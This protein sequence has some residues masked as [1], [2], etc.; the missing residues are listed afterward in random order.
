MRSRLQ[1]LRRRVTMRANDGERSDVPQPAS[2]LPRPPVIIVSLSV[3]A[4][5]VLT[6]W[7]LVQPQPLLIQGDADATRIDI[8]ARVDGRVAKRL[9]HRGQDG[10][11]GA[12]LVT[13]D[14]P[15]LLTKLTQAAACRA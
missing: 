2:S 1:W 8:A 3:A 12:V 4:I 9:V 11:A 5:V 6:L 10:T 15:Q 13:I 7:Y 14:N